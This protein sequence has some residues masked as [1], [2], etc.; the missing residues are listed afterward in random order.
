MIPYFL[1]VFVLIGI[2]IG[3]FLELCGGEDEFEVV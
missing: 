1:V 2:I 3:S